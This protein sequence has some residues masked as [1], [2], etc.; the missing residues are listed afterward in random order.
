MCKNDLPR[1]AHATRRK[2]TGGVSL[3]EVMVVL[4]VIGILLSASAP[5][6]VRSVE[7]AHADMSGANLRAIWN[8]QRLYWLEN[9]TYASSLSIL[10]S[11][12]L[13]DP[14]V[15]SG[16][17]RYSYAITFA[18]ANG[19]TATATRSGS[20]HWSGQFVMSESGQ[21]TGVVTATGENNI[22]PGF[23]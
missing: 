3:M 17:P 14:T 16:S 7:Q 18:D 13:L 8:A 1:H 2:A 6:F 21:L 20:S 19:F 5:S 10:E 23:Q 22:V 4:T 15:V 12:D 9:H 11:T